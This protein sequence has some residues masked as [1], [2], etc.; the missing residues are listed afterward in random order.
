LWGKADEL[1]AKHKAGQNPNTHFCEIL[2]HPFAGSK[3]HHSIRTVK[4]KRHP[5]YRNPPS[6]TSLTIFPTRF[7]L[8]YFKFSN[9]LSFFRTWRI[10]IGPSHRNSYGPP[11]IRKRGIRATREKDTLPPKRR[12]EQKINA[13]PHT[14]PVISGLA[15]APPPFSFCSFFFRLLSHIHRLFLCNK[16]AS[17]HLLKQNP[18]L[19]HCN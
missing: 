5:P 3:D 18:F 13:V 7:V 11:R 10:L 1:R 16:N 19:D 2:F 14:H 9:L 17:S 6:S 15:F 4:R 8:S 12:T